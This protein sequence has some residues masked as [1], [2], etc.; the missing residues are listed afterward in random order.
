MIPEP[1]SETAQAYRDL[2]PA[3]SNPF[4]SYYVA[5]VLLRIANEAPE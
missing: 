3:W 5:D 1:A 2:A 4:G